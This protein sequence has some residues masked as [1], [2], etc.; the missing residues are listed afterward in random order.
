MAERGGEGG[1]DVQSMQKTSYS[2]LADDAR[3]QVL[4]AAPVKA[5]KRVY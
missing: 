4:C 3:R 2:Y 5:W 1:G